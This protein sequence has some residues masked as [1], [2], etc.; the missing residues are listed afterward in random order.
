MPNNQEFN[1]RPEDRDRVHFEILDHINVI[2]ERNNG[3]TKEVNI[4]AWNGREPRI[5]VR[6]WDPSHMRMSRGITLT[7]DQAMRLAEA[8][9]K[10]FGLEIASKDQTSKPQADDV[11]DIPF[12]DPGVTLMNEPQGKAQQATAPA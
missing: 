12:D 2:G 11:Q 1:Q 10:R 5:D 9:G 3:W 4:V 8:L 6:D 7:D